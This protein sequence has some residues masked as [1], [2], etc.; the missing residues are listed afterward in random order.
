MKLYELTEAYRNIYELEDEEL[1]ETLDVIQDAIEDKAVSIAKVIKNIDSDI[2]T[3]DKEIE[4]LQ[5]RKT[6]MKKKRTNLKAFLKN[7]MECIGKKKLSTPIFS[8]NIQKN[9][10]SLIIN[11]ESKIPSEYFVISKDVDKNSIKAMIKDGIEIEGVELRQSES[12]RIR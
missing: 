3:L 9:A 7:A 12:L 6:S 4:R 5:A 11:D 10:P 1:Q 8:F 2:D